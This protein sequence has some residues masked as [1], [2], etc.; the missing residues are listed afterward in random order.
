MSLLPSFDLLMAYTSD[1]EDSDSCL[2]SSSRPA[3][4]RVPWINQPLKIKRIDQ[5]SP[6][7]VT[8][9]SSFNNKDDPLHAYILDLFCNDPITDM[10]D[11]GVHGIANN[12][13]LLILRDMCDV[14][15]AGRITWDDM[16]V[17]Y[18]FDKLEK[19]RHVLSEI[20]A[21]SADGEAMAGKCKSMA[22]C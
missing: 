19:Y 9:N 2:N 1:M 8:G 4:A 14:V 12:L 6:E 17:F 13:H 18:Q 11:A 10:T 20:S 3:K 7:P 5:L 22:G 15:D 21:N 16:Q